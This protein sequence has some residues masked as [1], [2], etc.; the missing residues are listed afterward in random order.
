MGKII[1]GKAIAAGIREG[2][3]RKVAQLRDEKGIIPKLDVILVGENPPSLAYVGMKE[4]AA[5]EVGIESTVHR[6]PSTIKEESLIELVDAINADPASHGILVQL[7][8]PKGIS[9]S[10][11]ISEILP[12]KD[13]DGLHPENMG[14][15]FKGE[16]P[17]FSPCTP[18]GAMELLLSTGVD[19]AGKKAVVVGRS[20]LVGK[21]IAMLL[22]QRH[23]TITWCHT[24]T[25]NLADEIRQA[26]ILIA[27]AGNPKFIKGNMIKPGAI[28]IDVGT[29]RTEKGITGD[30]DFESAKDVASYI[31]PVP[32][33]VGPMTIAMLL[34]N[35]VSSAER[36]GE[37]LPKEPPEV[38]QIIA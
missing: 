15:L 4:R 38:G 32:G 12:S 11:V 5:L 27:A 19:I 1:D 7:P 23:A 30:V 29:T 35:V 37:A 9:E 36:V 34:K 6:L 10:R 31:T 21:P 22:L 20:N 8:L 33:G 16:K 17:M 26:D 13:V 3:K 24:R 28:V 14:R 25:K 18:L 2:L